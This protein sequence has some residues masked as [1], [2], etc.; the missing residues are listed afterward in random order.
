MRRLGTNMERHALD[1]SYHTF[2]LAGALDFANEYSGIV[3]GKTLYNAVV[4]TKPAY[5][6]STLEHQEGPR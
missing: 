5:A 4:E 3:M 6:G 2:D 1:A